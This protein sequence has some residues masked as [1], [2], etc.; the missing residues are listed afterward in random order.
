M[1]NLKNN[2]MKTNSYLLPNRFKIFGWVISVPCALWS[3]IYLFGKPGDAV[4]PWDAWFPTERWYS[5]ML[6]FCGDNRWAT[7]GM[8]LLMA[9]LLFVA[10]SKEKTEDEYIMKLRGDSLIWAVFANSILMILLSV[11]VYGGWFLYVSFFNL[12]TVLILFIIKFNISMSNVRKEVSS[13]E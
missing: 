11:T 10:F 7:I 13:E 9:G 8:V 4:K 2:A 1:S 6:A 5:V 12:Y 3:L